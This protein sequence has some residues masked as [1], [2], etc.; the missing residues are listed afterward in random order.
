MQT[1]NV[2]LTEPTQDRNVRLAAGTY[3]C[4]EIADNG[5]GIEADVLPRIFEPFFTTKGTQPSRPRAGAGLWH[6]DQPRRRRG[7]FQPA[8]RG[9]VG[10]DLSA[11]GKD[12]SSRESAG[13]DEDLHGTET[14]LVVDDESLLLTMAET[15]LTEL[16]L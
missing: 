14:I 16:R 4:V 6:R 15:I 11:G 1:R 3:V 5:A 10:A 8:G 13:A 9:H 7:G 2:E 12:S